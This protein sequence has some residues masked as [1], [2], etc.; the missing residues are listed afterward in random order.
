MVGRCAAAATGRAATTAAVRP[1]ALHRR[2]RP[3]ESRR[4]R[5]AP[6]LSPLRTRGPAP[7]PSARADVD[8]RETINSE[9]TAR[10]FVRACRRS[11]FPSESRRPRFVR[12]L[13]PVSSGRR[14]FDARRRIGASQ[15]G[16]QGRAP[17]MSR[18]RVR[19][20]SLFP[21]KAESLCESL[22]RAGFVSAGRP[23]TAPLRGST[24]RPAQAARPARFAS[25]RLDRAGA[26]G[27]EPGGEQRNGRQSPLRSRLCPAREGSPRF[28]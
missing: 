18:S 10:S 27:Y 8:D 25:P 22:I 17:K 20:D 6:L 16:N 23:F 3:R 28:P 26:S 15:I 19:F 21:E 9:R 2:S 12:A 14:R 11:L 4:R 7:G 1:A 13:S 24:R 5:F